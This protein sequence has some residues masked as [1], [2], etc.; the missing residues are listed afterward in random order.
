VA[1]VTLNA[2][3]ADLRIPEFTGIM[4]YGD[5][6]NADPRTAS[7]TYNMDTR[8][9]VLRP[10]SDQTLLTPSVAAPIETLA[11]L[12]RRWLSGS[13]E[14]TVL[15]AASGGQL[16]YMVVGG[17]SWTQMALP[18]GWVGTGYA[19]NVWSYV[20]YEINPEGA[21]APVDVLLLSNAQDGMIYVRGDN[22]TVAT[23]TTPKK[24][25]VI[26]RYAERIWGGGITDDPDT[27]V[28][29]APFNPLDWAA[30][31]EIPEDGAGDVMQPSW[32]GDSFH[33]LMPLGSQLIAF[34]KNRI[35][36]IMN[37]DPSEYVF[38]EQYGGGTA[39]FNTIAVDRERILMLGENGVMQYDGLSAAPYYQET[40]KD[41]WNSLNLAALGQACA[42]IWRD[43]YFLAIPTGVSA[44]NNAVVIYN[45]RENTW[46]YRN[47]VAVESFLPTDDKLYFTSRATPGR[48]YEWG[49]DSWESGVAVSASWTGQ[50]NDLNQKAMLKG[51]FDVYLAV[52]AKD[53]V[54]VSV[55]IETEKKTKT[56]AVIFPDTSATKAIQKRLHFGGAGRRFR[57]LISS[58]ATDAWRIVGGI[59]VRMEID[60]D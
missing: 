32:D 5:G 45:I 52:E 24:F 53:A 44:Y 29:S 36:R 58:D 49:D 6:I 28:Y 11:S 8:G 27:L 39:F 43:C 48:I 7:V 16:Y 19:S 33:A 1:Y 23:V 18:A 38:K 20:A 25:G 56:K 26:A 21:E 14:K 3:D 4:Q 41:I 40:C 46:L 17:S 12:Y 50:W 60:P 30:N 22:L 55:S 9:G 37:T 35:W 31:T 13:G 59:Q 15:I 34:K 51:G 57:L 10:A 42:C 2:Y 54:T 47:N